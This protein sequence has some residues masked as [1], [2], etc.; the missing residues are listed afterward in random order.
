M[1]A[2][3]TLFNVAADGVT[4]WLEPELPFAARPEVVVVVPCSAGKVDLE[5]GELR[6]VGELY[7]GAFHTYAR[8]HA[9]RLGADRVLI[10][11]AWHGLVPLEHLS[12]PYDVTIDDGAARAKPGIVRRQAAALGL[13]DADVVVVS[14]CPNRYT[15]VLA[16]AIPDLVTPLAGAAGIGD[17]RGR[18]NRLTALA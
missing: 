13:L 15:A 8:R 18:L 16:E 6:P 11:S 14:F 3:G 7:T 9:E 1:T 5:F 4:F 17:Q 10:L 2:A 12:G